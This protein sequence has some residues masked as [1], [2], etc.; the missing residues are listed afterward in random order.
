MDNGCICCRLGGGQCGLA[1]WNVWHLQ[2]WKKLQSACRAIHLSFLLTACHLCNLHPDTKCRRHST[3]PICV[4]IWNH[5]RW[6][7]WW[8]WLVDNC[9]LHCDCGSSVIWA[10]TVLDKRVL[11]RWWQGHVALECW[12][13]SGVTL[14]MSALFFR[15]LRRESKK[16]LSRLRYWNARWLCYI[17]V[18]INVDFCLCC[19]LAGTGIRICRVADTSSPGLLGP[20]YMRCLCCWSVD[21]HRI[22]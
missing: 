17:A 22:E 6:W 12:Q 11:Y 9:W 14:A 15:A 13:Q 3:N 10:P 7:W 16:S 20:L 21:T 4:V 19:C 18:M 5:Q 1:H 8:C 2:G